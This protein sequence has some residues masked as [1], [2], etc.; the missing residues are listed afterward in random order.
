MTKDIPTQQE[1]I[2]FIEQHFPKVIV[3]DLASQ[4]HGDYATQFEAGEAIELR[5]EDFPICTHPTTYEFGFEG[6]M[7]VMFTDWIHS[8]GWHCEC[9]D[10]GTYWLSVWKY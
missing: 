1:L 6:G 7:S 9:H 3:S 10:Y 2:D 5:G 8:I 4:K